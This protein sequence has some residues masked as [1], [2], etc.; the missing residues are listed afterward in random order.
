MGLPQ[1]AQLA[2]NPSCHAEEA[3][4]K[5]SIP[6]RGRSPRGGHGKPHQYSCQDN[7]TDREAW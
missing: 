2:K 1:V 7:P 6:G 3:G 5:G 4:D